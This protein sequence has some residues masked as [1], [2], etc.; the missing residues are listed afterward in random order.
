MVHRRRPPPPSSS[1]RTIAASSRRRS[2]PTEGGGQQHVLDGSIETPTYATPPHIDLTVDVTVTFAGQV[3]RTNGSHS[4][5]EERKVTWT[6]TG[7]VQ[8]VAAA[9]PYGRP[10]VLWA[11]L[12]TVLVLLALR[13]AQ[14]GNRRVRE[15][16]GEIPPPRSEVEGYVPVH[17]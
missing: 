11:L 1:A 17:R 10:W 6:D 13:L 2:S 12:G 8:A 15:R 3:L 5:E 7:Q 16:Q 14:Q 9:Q 4:G